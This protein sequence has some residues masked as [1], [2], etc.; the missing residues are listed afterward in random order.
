MTQVGYSTVFIDANKKEHYCARLFA[1]V[2]NNMRFN[3][4]PVPF[5]PQVT[6]KTYD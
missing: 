2:D 6:N 4:N 3:L 5:F 1:R